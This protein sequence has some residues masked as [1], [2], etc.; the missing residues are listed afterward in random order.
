MIR[1]IFVAVVLL[2]AWPAHAGNVFLVRDLEVFDADTFNV[3]YKIDAGNC[4]KCGLFVVARSRLLGADA[5]ETSRRRRTIDVTEKELELGKEAR[6]YVQD[7][8]AKHLSAGEI[9]VDAGPTDNYG[10]R[11]VS[12]YFAGQSLA[13][14]LIKNCHALPYFKKGG[15]LVYGKVAEGCENPRKE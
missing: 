7:L 13:D 12:L 4:K 2:M 9:T 3:G 6:E 5:W 8:I 11:L 15:S 10:R 1:A 14:L